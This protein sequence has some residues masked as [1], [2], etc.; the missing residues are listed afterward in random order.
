VSGA[1]G[2]CHCLAFLRKPDALKAVIA[3]AAVA[4]PSC[5]EPSVT[6]AVNIEVN[7][8][9]P[10]AHYAGVDKRYLEPGE[11]GNCYA[12]AFTKQAELAKGG[13]ESSIMV[14]RLKTGEGHAVLLTSDGYL[15]NRFDRV[16]SYAEVGCI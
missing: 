16:V 4:L 14:W 12:Q 2:L 7:H 3:L 9:R 10:Y 1:H 8:T 13:V 6:E 11:A 15:D 5:A